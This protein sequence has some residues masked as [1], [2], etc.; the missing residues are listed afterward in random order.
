MREHLTRVGLSNIPDDIWVPGFNPR[1]RQQGS[2]RA[3]FL[4]G[5][6][7]ERLSVPVV[8]KRQVR[9]RVEAVMARPLGSDADPGMPN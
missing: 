7:G 6:A 8:R 2:C 1:H 9:N 3:A 5:K 4:G